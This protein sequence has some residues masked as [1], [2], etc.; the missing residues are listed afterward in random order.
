MYKLVPKKRKNIFLKILGFIAACAV[1]KELLVV[2][3]GPAPRSSRAI[4]KKT[5]IIQRDL[6]RPYANVNL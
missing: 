5:K 2:L 6:Y 3:P 4:S 1:I